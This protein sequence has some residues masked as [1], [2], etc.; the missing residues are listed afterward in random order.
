M[1]AGES[2]WIIPAKGAGKA[3]TAVYG[4]FGTTGD[5]QDDCVVL[6][7][8]SSAVTVSQTLL[9][10]DIRLTNCIGGPA[11]TQLTDAHTIE[12]S[13]TWTYDPDLHVVY[14]DING[15][16][17]YDKTDQ[18]YLTTKTVGATTT[19]GAADG[20]AATTGATAWTVRLTKAG[21]YPA[22]TF[23]VMG[24]S[25]FSTH[26]A[27]A[28][29][30][31]AATGADNLDAGGIMEREDGQ[32][33]WVPSAAPTTLPKGIIPPL[34]SIRITTIT[35]AVPDIRV[36]GISVATP[37][38]VA[39]TPFNVLAEVTNAGKLAGTGL[40]LSK[41]DGRLVDARATPLLGAGEK[42]TMLLSIRAE[43]PGT[44]NLGVNDIFD[45]IE[46]TGEA[47]ASAGTASTAALEAK[48]AALEARL[49]AL[50][51]QPATGSAPLQVQGATA[52][53]KSPAVEPILLLLLIG[54][55]VL[56][57]RRN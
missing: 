46:V 56:T 47:S 9:P 7:T 52:K 55:L 11:G 43:N 8:T 30:L 40:V 54:A 14:V 3:F 13:R 37:E 33:L 21:P 28:Q 2:D 39:G 29:L 10:K 49:A 27:S 17:K 45:V 22:G 16:A 35:P 5:P 19:A 42:A 38:I 53:A 25:D 15:N 23:V 1:L 34:D 51:A 20:M 31:F 6:R 36:T 48:I 4:T 12:M 18:V 50:E 57:R 41:L 32:W 26:G 24:D 44:V